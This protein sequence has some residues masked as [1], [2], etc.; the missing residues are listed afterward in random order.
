MHDIGEQGWLP[1]ELGAWGDSPVVTLAQLGRVMARELPA[2][3]M[4]VLTHCLGLQ[5]LVDGSQRCNDSLPRAI[6]ACPFIDSRQS[7]PG[8]LAKPVGEGWV[9]D[10][11]VSWM[12]NAAD[13]CRC[14]V[15]ALV[16]SGVTALFNFDLQQP[17]CSLSEPLSMFGLWGVPVRRLGLRS[18]QVNSE[19]LVATERA[20]EERLNEGYRI[21]RWGVVGMLLGILERFTTEATAYATVRTQGGRKIIDHIPVRQ[22]LER[23][24]AGT[25]SLAQWLCRLQTCPDLAYMMTDV[26]RHALSASD[27][28]LQVFGGSGYICPSLPERCW[29]DV[30]QALA[31]CG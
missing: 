2:A 19:A 6:S 9:L 20:A 24:A 17:G 4:P 13:G 15:A 31:L 21:I 18:V 23:M 11:E 16:G 28:G 8:V 26:R 10:G 3:F 25:D 1:E 30:R 12:V 29:R 27:C 7:G 14:V 22:L 5:L